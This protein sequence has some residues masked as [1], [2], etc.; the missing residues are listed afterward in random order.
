MDRL[1]KRTITTPIGDLV[2]VGTGDAIEYIQF[3]AERLPERLRSAVAG[4]KAFAT[5]VEQFRE[6]FAGKRT[7]FDFP[8][9]LKAEGFK[10][11][12]LLALRRV[13]YGSTISY[14]EL[15]ERAGS[16]NAFRAAGTACATNPLPIVIPC[17]RVLKADG[18]LGGFG[19]G[20]DMKRKLLDLEQAHYK[21]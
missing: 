8:I 13:T 6:Y 10:K 3:G 19:G 9:H 20:L 2:L 4:E 11:A 7:S 14:K 21:R 15:A 16:G 5:A 17:H 18:S 12:A 1:T